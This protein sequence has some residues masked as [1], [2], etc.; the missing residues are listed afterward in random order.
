MD[1]TFDDIKQILAETASAQ[2]VHATQLAE[3]EKKLAT[4]K[5]VWEQKL[6]TEKVVWEQKLATEKVVWEQNFAAEKAEREQKLAFQKDDLDKTIKQTQKQLGE[7]GNKLGS[8]AEGLAYPTVERIMLEELGMTYVSQNIKV[9]RGGDSL[10]IDAFGYSNGTKNVVMVGEIKSHFREEHINQLENTCNK[11]YDFMP[12][13]HGKA[14]NGMVIFVSGNKNAIQKAIKNG[15][16]VVQA[17]DDNF[18]RLTPEK[19]IAKN[20]AK[21][22]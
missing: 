14:V 10:E 11:I 8:F 5:V 6:A 7:L 16:Y 12:E 22:V 18:K 4:E 9:E 17:N 2:K 21:V 20:F 1:I 3:L 13:H 15:I 19:F